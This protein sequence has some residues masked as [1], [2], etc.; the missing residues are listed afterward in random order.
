MAATQCGL[1]QML[2]H[3]HLFKKH[4][5]NMI[6]CTDDTFLFNT[7]L[8]ME[9]FEFCKA[10]DLHDASE[11]KQMLIRNLEGVFADD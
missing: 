5:G 1:V 8:S 6:V 4:K 2:K 9:L 3:I 11:I 7:N 10:I